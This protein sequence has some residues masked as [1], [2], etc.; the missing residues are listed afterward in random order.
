MFSFGGPYGGGFARGVGFAGH[1]R[2]PWNMDFDFDFNFGGQ[3]R[4][5]WDGP[6]VCRSEE[7]SNGSDGESS[8]VAHHFKTSTQVC[9]SSDSAYKCTTTIQSAEGQVTKV[10]L[11]ECC[12]GFSRSS[13]DFGCPKKLQLEDLPT[14]A[15]SL[16][17]NDL[18]KAVSQAGLEEELA[19]GNFTVFAPQD[20]AFPP[21]L[22]NSYLVPGEGI[23]LRDRSWK[24]SQKP[25]RDEEEEEEEEEIQ[26]LETVVLGHLLPEP[27]RLSSFS[28]EDVLQ[29]GSPLDSTVRVN[30]YSR[31]ERMTTVNCVKVT[32]S[33]HLASNGVL[34]VVEELLP[35]VTS[36]L[37]DF[38]RQD[39]QFSYLKTALARVNLVSSLQKDGQFTLLAPTNSA[40]QRLD[41]GL[42]D[43]LMSGNPVCL[44][45][46]VKNHILP[47][48]ICTPIIQGK[49]KTRN[50]LNAYVNLTRTE[51][52]KLFVN[53]AQV[54]RSDVMAT[55]GVMHVIDAVLIPDD[56]LDLVSVAKKNGLTEFV[57]LAD[58]AGMTSVLQNMSDVT[59]FA[60][61]NEAIQALPPE[62]MKKLWSDP[63]LLQSV[64]NFHVVPEE[65]DCRHMF[66]NRRLETLNPKGRVYVN[67]YSSFPFGRQRVSTVQ[68][69]PITERNVASCNGLL[70]VV[71]RVLLP[72]SGNVVDVLAADSNYSTL[73]RLLKKGGLA[74]SL[75]EEG[76]FTLFAPTNEAFKELGKETLKELEGDSE[77][78]ASILKL[79]INNGHLCCSGILHGSWWHPQR[80]RTLGGH[81]LSLSRDYRGQALVNDAVIGSCD[82][83]A[84]NGVVHGIDSVLM[85]QRRQRNPWYMYL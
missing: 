65:I 71:D 64:L 3:K 29:T 50:Q 44:D 2:H 70:H 39:K 41:K 31:P 63:D 36:S 66:S 77:R 33:D 55:N 61:S 13:E 60:P 12:H 42:L 48:V 43:R 37:V 54:V 8:S 78:L 49:A 17:L 30:F 82:N 51:D 19:R 38:V 18:L 59:V 6:N 20:G 34:H 83:S 81:A 58:A 27:R 85:P 21:Q 32:S 10:E 22:L 11:Y 53:D 56:A 16:G 84:T 23:S 40:F 62:V 47:N 79:H 26:D 15:N 76:P 25:F 45:K 46:V 35:T 69:A 14:T 68:C 9:E 24:F 5:W 67:K 7:K 72:P 73:V 28:D 57:Q 80:V 1:H 52:K 74:D 75:Q 4:N